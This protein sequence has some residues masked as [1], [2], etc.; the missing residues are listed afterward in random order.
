MAAA[1]LE[2]EW[3]KRTEAGDYTGTKPGGDH[4]I[5][6]ETDKARE[7]DTDTTPRRGAERE[8]REMEDEE[9]VSKE[10]KG[11]MELRWS[12]KTARDCLLL[13]FPTGNARG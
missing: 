12:D 10:W 3:I 7:A 5:V 9:D 11:E 8:C 2:D 4:S 13:L 1:Q 6:K